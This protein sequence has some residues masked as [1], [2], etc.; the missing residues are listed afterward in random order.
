MRSARGKGFDPVDQRGTV[1]NR[2]K[3]EWRRTGGGSHGCD[4]LASVGKWDQ[5]RNMLKGMTE[6]VGE[7]GRQERKGSWAAAGAW[8]REGL[9]CWSSQEWL[10]PGAFKNQGQWPRDSS[11]GEALWSSQPSPQPSASLPIFQTEDC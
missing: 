7:G 5:L 10:W 2:P 4:L 8:Q 1:G 9:C 3:A 11:L 6:G